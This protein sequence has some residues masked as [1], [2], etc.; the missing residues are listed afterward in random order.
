MF[1]FIHLLRDFYETEMFENWK[2]ASDNYHIYRARTSKFVNYLFYR[3]E[4]SVAHWLS[5]ILLTN[6][7][8]VIISC[9]LINLSDIINEPVCK[10]ISV[11]ASQ[12]GE[13]VS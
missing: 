4:I 10:T 12:W 1:D 3:R 13:I 5:P 7:G 6:T 9:F 8:N 2:C 11:P